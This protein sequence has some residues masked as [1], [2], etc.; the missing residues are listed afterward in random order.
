M[1]SYGASLAIALPTFGING[2]CWPHF[3]CGGQKGFE[4]VCICFILE[5]IVHKS[6]ACKI[7]P[8]I[9]NFYI[10]K[11]AA[12]C[13]FH[14]LRSLTFANAKLITRR[15]NVPWIAAAE[16]KQGQ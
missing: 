11:A 15:C 9:K 14:P 5:N 4:R 7:H 1:I 8:N 3:A 6:I 2:K 10:T 13:V 12:K 16:A